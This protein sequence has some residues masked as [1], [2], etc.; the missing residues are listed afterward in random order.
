MSSWFQ[1]EHYE[2]EDPIEEEEEEEEEEILGSSFC[3]GRN[4]ELLE[5]PDSEASFLP[6]NM[7]SSQL[8]FRFKE[9]RRPR[10]FR[11]VLFRSHRLINHL[12]LAV[13]EWVSC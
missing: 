3:V 8:A 5:L 13:F 4:E 2:E 10:G 12:V 11:W 9:V 1:E 7:D 6:G